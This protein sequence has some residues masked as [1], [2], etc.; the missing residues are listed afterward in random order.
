MRIWIAMGCGL[1]ALTTGITLASPFFG[2]AHQVRDMPIFWLALGLCATGGLFLILP[3]MIRATK[4][5]TPD[6]IKLLL[7]GMLTTGLAM[8]LVLF[9]SEPVLEDDYQRYL[10]D[11][12]VTANGLN[13]Y[14]KSPDAAKVA[15]P[16]LSQLGRLAQESGPLLGSINHP[17][18]RTI[19]PPIAQGV[20]A[21][22]YKLDPWSLTTWRSLILL[23]DL[24]TIPILLLLLRDL[25]RSPLWA[26][27]Y[28][29]NPIVLK[30]LFNSAHME[31]II[32][33]LVLGGLLF[34]IRKRPI[35]A[36]A[37]LTAAA[38]A[39]VWPLI[40]L[41]LVW[42]G[43]LDKPKKLT[44]AIA[45]TGVACVL[46]AWPIVITGFDTS[47]GFVAYTSQWKAN[48]ALMPSLEAALRWGLDAAH[49]NTLQPGLL[50]RLLVVVSLGIIVLWQCRVNAESAQD[51]AWKFF[52]VSCAMFLLSPAQFPWY[53]LW[54]L[55]LLACFPSPAMLSLSA[56]L[57][58]YYTAFHFHAHGAPEFFAGHM[59]WFIWLPTWGLL[60]WEARHWLASLNSPFRHSQ[61][62]RQIS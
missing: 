19:Y 20:F 45:M 60:L 2:Y 7:W 6:L 25:G 8:R 49:I 55:P 53:F 31:A 44:L 17:D 10:W 5:F 16:E 38:G 29:W 40:L 59:V 48:S 24:A 51:L 33:P 36:T 58:L 11:G 52:I 4:G 22:A 30:E 43:W 23:L 62:A 12:A 32:V 28:W 35:S 54:A 15:D 47:S 41:P 50:A 13:P 56:T 61:S 27:L 14:E 34:A 46:F 21:L 9:A 18:L 57:P 39:K 26:A 1:L 37:C 3:W 42:R